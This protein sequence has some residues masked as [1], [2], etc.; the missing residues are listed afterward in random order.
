MAARSWPVPPTGSFYRLTDQS[1]LGRAI[2]DAEGAM[3][4][5]ADGWYGVSGSP[6]LQLAGL[7][8]SKESGSESITSRNSMATV[9]A[10]LLERD[11]WTVRAREMLAR[12]AAL[13]NDRFAS[14]SFLEQLGV[15]A[16][17]L[18]SV[19]ALAMVGAWIFAPARLFVWSLRLSRSWTGNSL[20]RLQGST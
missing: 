19:L 10:V 8:S 20:N 3:V 5:S 2:L 14:L 15:I 18:Y 17:V 6:G 13:A 4:V 12:Q 16:A 7:E 11:R 1:E 9:N